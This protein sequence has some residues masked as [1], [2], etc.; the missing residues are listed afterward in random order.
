MKEDIWTKCNGI[1]RICSLNETAWRIVESQEISATRKLVD[2][3]E[4]QDILE[5]MIESNKPPLNNDHHNLHP[6]LYTPFRYPPLQ[7]GSR[8]GNKIEPALWYGSLKLTTA[9]FEKAF[10]KFNFLRASEAQ[11]NIVEERLTAFSTRIKTDKGIKLTA[12]PFAEYTPIISSPTSY[13]SSQMLGSAMRNAD[14]KAFIFKS[15][16]DLNKENNI[17]LFTA[18]AFSQKKPDESS[19]QSWQCIAHNHTI[20]F[21][22]T[23]SI[24]PERHYF[25]IENFMIDGVLPFP[26]C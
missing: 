17:A 13:D 7:F 4:E 11:F 1:T 15:A 5:E 24:Y 25:S 19:F 2:S 8:F 14:V 9:M 23:S 26:A 3:L 10:Y 20:E 12:S 18:A 21:V 22:R 6:L 16:R